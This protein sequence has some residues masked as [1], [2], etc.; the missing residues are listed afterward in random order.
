VARRTFTD[1]DANLLLRV[2]NRGDVTATLRGQ[3]I[4]DA[5]LRCANEYEHPELQKIGDETLLATTDTFT[6][7][8]N[9]DIWWPE[10]VKDATTGR[11]IR[12][13]DKERIENVLTKSTGTPARCYWWGNKFYFDTKPATNLTIRLWY[14]RQPSEWSSA[15]SELNKIYD[16]I[17]ELYSTENALNF[18]REYDKAE[19]SAREAKAYAADMHLPT[20][21][22][23]MND[24]LNGFVADDR[25]RR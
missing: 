10:L 24:Y 5:L 11:I 15:S 21:K 23:R 3:W 1:I 16:V 25:R 17:L 8:V 4:N 9:T 19:L 6:P 20:A 14:K 22:A 18:L 13:G 2:G 7:T 12:P